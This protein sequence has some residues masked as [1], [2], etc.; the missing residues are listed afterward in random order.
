[1]S[2]KWSRPL[3]QPAVFDNPIEAGAR[4]RVA[5]AAVS[6]RQHLQPDAVLVAVD[7][8]LD[9]PLNLAAGGALAPERLARAAEVVGLAGLQGAGQRL[10]VHPGDHQ[11]L[12]GPRRAWSPR[13]SSHRRRNGE[14]GPRRAPERACRGRSGSRSW[15]PYG[16]PTARRATLWPM[17]QPH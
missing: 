17:S 7:A 15:A 8:G 12:A 4:A 10:G 5:G 14:R 1:M 2:A 11:H 3:H 16:A 6:L 13:R 9:D